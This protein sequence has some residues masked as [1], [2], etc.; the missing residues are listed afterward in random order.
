MTGGDRPLAGRRALVTG[1]SRGLGREMVLAFAAA[2]ADVA[3]VSRKAQACEALA[4]EVRETTGVR[5]FSYPAH[6][7]DWDGLGR[8]VDAVYD[9]VGGLD[10]LVN[11]AGIAPLYPSLDQLSEELFDKVIG[12][13]LKGPFRLTALVGSRMAA[14]AAAARSSISAVSRR[15][16]PR[17]PT[18]RTPRR[19]R[20]ST[21]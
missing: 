13:N 7:G 9:E 16:G 19:R 10:I 12:V 15:S 6:V 1:G 3:I 17:R 21:F 11:N 18:S 14:S 5:A 8:L 20:A 4:D 2:G